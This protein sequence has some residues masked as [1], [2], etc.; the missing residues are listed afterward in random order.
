MKVLP[1][2]FSNAQR[3]FYRAMECSVPQ[4][5]VWIRLQYIKKRCAQTFLLCVVAVVKIISTGKKMYTIRCEKKYM[6]ISLIYFCSSVRSF[7]TIYFRENIWFF[8]MQDG[9]Y[10]KIK[11][12]DLLETVRNAHSG[13]RLLVC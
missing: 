13:I 8:E 11:L 3:K 5:P 9:K 4:L 12:T 2:V 6:K 1:P 7:S 10:H